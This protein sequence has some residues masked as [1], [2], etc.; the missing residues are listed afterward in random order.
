MKHKRFTPIGNQTNSYGP[1]PTSREETLANPIKV[2]ACHNL[3]TKDQW[4]EL[5][6]PE[7]LQFD[8]GIE[9]F[10]PTTSGELIINTD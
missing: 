9:I 5:N 4:F 3:G 6:R 2:V 7:S 1:L 10:T 8:C